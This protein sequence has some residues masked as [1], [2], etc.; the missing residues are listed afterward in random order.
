MRAFAA[1]VTVFFGFGMA[2]MAACSSDS[3]TSA[4]AGAAG[5]AGDTSTGGST[6]GTGGGPVAEAGSAGSAGAA[7]APA[8]CSFES[9]ACQACL[10]S[11]CLDKLTA[12]SSDAACDGALTDL[13]GCACDPSK[14][15]LDCETAFQSG[16]G[17]K[18]TIVITCFNDNCATAC[19]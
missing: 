2:S 12:C 1:C 10:K 6:A 8:G 16:G 5:E 7:G 15:T 19:Q 3:T 11:N 14:T 18:A 13:Q 17:D 9:D 4:A